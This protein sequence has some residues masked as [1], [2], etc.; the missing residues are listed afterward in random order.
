[1]LLLIPLSIGLSFQ[2]RYH[3]GLG[4]SRADSKCPVGKTVVP[5]SWSNSGMCPDTLGTSYRCQTTCAAE[6]RKVSK[7]ANLGKHTSLHQWPLKLGA[8]GPKTLAFVKELGK[9]V[10]REMGEEKATSHLFEHLSVAIQ[11]GNA[12]NTMGT[13]FRS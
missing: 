12:T 5:W 13:C 6:E 9:R 8:F 10:N 3:H 1:M 11:R 7:Y 2:Q 4:M